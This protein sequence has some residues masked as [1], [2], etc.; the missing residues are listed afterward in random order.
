MYIKPGDEV[1]EI[2]QNIR[3]NLRNKTHLATTLGYGP[4]YLHSTGQLHK[5]DSGKGIFLQFTP[6]IEADVPIPE[7]AGS[8]D[9]SI[10][11]GTLMMAQAFGDAKALED[12]G[13]E[14]I[15][16]NLG[17]HPVEELHRFNKLITDEVNDD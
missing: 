3:V 13:R 2:L 12:E 1:D 15:R 16:F 6:E 10:T 7:N 5:G 17:K 4:R 9:S 11:F 14:V 8:D